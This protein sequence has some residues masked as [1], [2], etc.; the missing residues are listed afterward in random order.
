MLDGQKPYLNIVSH[1]ED[2]L[3]RH[4]DSHLG[5]D[6]AN[7]DDAERR[8]QVMLDMIGDGRDVSV[9]DFGCGYSHLLGYMRKVNFQP[10]RYVG[11]DISPDFIE[12]SREKYPEIEYLRL[13]V[14]DEG[15]TIPEFDYILMNGVFTEK[16]GLSFDEM[17]DYFRAVIGKTFPHCRKGMA[18]NVRS[19]QV[20][21]EEVDLFHLPLDKCAWFLARDVSR[22]YAIRQDYGLEEYTVY[23][24]RAP[25]Y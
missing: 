18:F 16:G 3:R 7:A 22:H 4:G 25:K 20:E 8:Y 24:Y 9:L 19:S 11:L 21:T 13:D 23:L 15:V 17:F 6:W 10:I 2:C 1:Y 5:V 12:V 14:L